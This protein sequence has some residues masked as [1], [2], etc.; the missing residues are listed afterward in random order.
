MDRFFAYRKPSTAAVTIVSGCSLDSPSACLANT[1]DSDKRDMFT[2]IE[3]RTIRSFLLP[4]GT[5]CRE[6]VELLEQLSVAD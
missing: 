3:T 1:T 2:A 5:V 4:I 6:R